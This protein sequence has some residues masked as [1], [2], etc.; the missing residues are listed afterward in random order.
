MT[1]KLFDNDTLKINQRHNE[2]RAND[3]SFRA[4]RRKSLQNMRLMDHVTS[5]FNDNIGLSTPAV[6]LDIE[7]V[8]WHSEFLYK[9]QKLQI[10]SSLN[11]SLAPFIEQKIQS[12]GSRRNVNAKRNTSK[13]TSVFLPVP[14]PLQSTYKVKPP[15]PPKA[16]GFIYLSSPMTHVYMP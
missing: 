15:P 8:T 10:S 5:N 3:S 2:E 11:C 13:S 1:S 16:E 9:L 6:F 12:L 4:R 7:K 14:S